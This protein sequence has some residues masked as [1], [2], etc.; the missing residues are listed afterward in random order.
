LEFTLTGFNGEIQSLDEREVVKIKVEN[1]NYRLL[2]DVRDVL[3]NFTTLNF[4][5]E[6]KLL[7]S[8]LL[9]EATYLLKGTYEHFFDVG[10]ISAAVS[11]VVT[12]RSV[13]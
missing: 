13:C 3:A 10:Q 9:P 7:L 2:V 8:S 11:G 5:L 1:K 6:N 4:E 12:R